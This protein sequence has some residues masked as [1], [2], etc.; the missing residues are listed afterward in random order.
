LSAVTVVPSSN[1]DPTA[2]AGILVI[3][4]LVIARIFGAGVVVVGVVV[5]GELAVVGGIGFLSRGMMCS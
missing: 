2:T 1:F 4:I 3:G 5:V